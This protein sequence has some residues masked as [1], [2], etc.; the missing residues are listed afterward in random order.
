MAKKITFRAMKQKDNKDYYKEWKMY[1]PEARI[2][3][4]KAWTDENA[5]LASYL[6]IYYED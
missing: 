4:S 1:H 5:D 6:E 2:L 3:S